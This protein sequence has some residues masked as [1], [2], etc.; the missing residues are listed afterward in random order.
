M[1]TGAKTDADRLRALACVT[2]APEFIVPWLDRFYEP[3][4]IDLVIEAAAGALPGDHSAAELDR[5]FRRAILERDG[6]TYA[7]ADLHTRY[8]LWAL[9]EDWH[10]I[11]PDVRL[12]L[13]EWEIAD[14]LAE[15]GA[16][17]EAILEGHDEESDQRDYTYLLL[18][19]AEQLI[20]EA[21]AIYLWPC[22][23]RSMWGNCDKSHAVCLRFGNDRGIG[24]ELS[25]DR[26]IA[27]LRQADAEGL[28]HT[29]YLASLHG[30]HGLCNCCSDCCFPILAGQRLGAEAVWPLRRHRAVQLEDLCTLCAKCVRRCPFKAITLD[31]K[32]E[33][34]LQID[35][36]L[37]RGCGLCSTGCPQG[38]IEMQAVEA[39][40]EVDANP[41]ALPVGENE[42][43]PDEVT[44]VDAAPAGDEPAV[45]DR[46]PA[47]D[48]GVPP[49][50]VQI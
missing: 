24:W 22:N 23:C 46:A 13:N 48:D 28:M 27:V 17:I 35:T 29:A 6:D 4:D 47:I 8:E 41:L 21:P 2:A 14:Y 32:R 44:V 31:R 18:D 7:P 50:A 36:V 3:E 40:G 30:H 37:C 39:P 9:F 5:A 33:P 19:E 34:A 42:L 26:A 10:D 38:A 1:A 20:R 16:G 15:V 11:P 43:L 12:Q 25:K 45:T 49:L